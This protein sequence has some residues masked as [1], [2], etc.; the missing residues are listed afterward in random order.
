MDLRIYSFIGE[1]IRPIE[2]AGI[3]KKIFNIKR[4][5]VYI[6]GL[7]WYLDPVS[8]FGLRLLKFQ[9]YES[10]I[11]NIIENVLNENDVF[12]DLG[13]NEGYFSVL[14]SRK[15]GSKGVVYSIEPQTRMWE[16]LNKNINKNHLT[17][18]V[19]LPYLVS[20][21]CKTSDIVLSPNINSGSSSAVK[22]T[23]NNFWEVETLD[24]ITL[25]QLFFHRNTEIKLIKI[26]IE[27]FEL[28]ALKGA[29]K[30]LENH[31][32]KNIIIEVH[33]EQLNALNQNV[34]EIYEILELNGYRENNGYF[35]CE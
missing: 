25:D 24:S 32:I 20:D 22:S 3:V 28:F 9:E 13:A 30:L 35:T 27:G 23:R 15:I 21:E 8:N 31:L 1:R 29:K 2:L 7:H 33:P 6:N 4:R 10:D 11:T 14:A 12:V 34:S 5:Y 18:I 26:D 17:N 19:V 16:V